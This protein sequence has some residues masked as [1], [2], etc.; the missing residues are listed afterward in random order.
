MKQPAV[1]AAVGTGITGE[2]GSIRAAYPALTPLAGMRRHTSWEVAVETT[3]K[4]SVTQSHAEARLIVD[5]ASLVE[6]GPPTT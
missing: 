4:S 2:T 5:A 6:D 3:N 1:P